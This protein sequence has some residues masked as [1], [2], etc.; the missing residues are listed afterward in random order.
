MR[1]RYTRYMTAWRLALFRSVGIRHGVI[2]WAAMI[3]AGGLDYAVNVL[4]GRWLQPVQY[5]IFVCVA[6]ILQVLVYLSVAIRNVVAVYTAKLGVESGSFKQVGA[7]VQRAWRWAWQWGLMATALMVLISPFLA[8]LLRLPNPWPLW[9]A[10]PAVVLL[11]FVRPV[12]DGALQGMQLFAGLGVVQVTQSLLRL[13]FAAG[14]I[15]LGCQAVGA[16]VAV[17]LAG[18]VVLMVAL[19]WLRPYFQARGEVV[20]R[21]VSWH[22]SSYTLLGL[23]AFGVLANL[24]ALFVKHFFSPRM[25]GD[26]GPVVTLAKVSLFL[27]LAMGIILLPKAVRR[28]AMG[29]DARPILFLALT[30]AL[31]PGLVVTIFY[32]LFPGL[33]V[34]TI[35]T[36]AYHNPGIVLALATLAASLYAGLNIWLNYALSLERP[37]F[38]YALVGV[39]VWQGVG[40]FLFGRESLVHMTLVMVS[41][42]VM[43]N[44]A[45]FITNWCI[46]PA[47]RAVR[48]EVVG[49]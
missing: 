22:Y 33:L 40:M 29:R 49:A 14:L 39:L 12:T 17:P 18:T 42:G 37:A 6:A 9:A 26:Y 36:D 5:G 3:L 25:A 46:V 20:A 16:I 8:R 31:A 7:F 34:S 44:L 13:L 4:A 35:F 43:G 30:G 1:A 2:M 38:I 19:R 10:S 23:A 24:D 48:A 21:P 11:F 47:P 28:R 15:W 27:P 32:F 41:A 45:G